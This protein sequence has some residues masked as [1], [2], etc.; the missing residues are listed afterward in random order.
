MAEL[1]IA[2][3]PR[4]VVRR[5]HATGAQLFVRGDVEASASVRRHRPCQAR[6]RRR[7]RERWRGCVPAG[8]FADGSATA[9]FGRWSPPTVALERLAGAIEVQ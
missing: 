3:H 1:S 9:E 4:I 6:Y 7:R 5:A 8:S 2:Q